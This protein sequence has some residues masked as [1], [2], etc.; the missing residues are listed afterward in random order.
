M[1]STS[2]DPKDIALNKN[3]ASS[4]QELKFILMGKR[5]KIFIL[6]GKRQKINTKYFSQVVFISAM[7]KKIK[8]R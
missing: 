8:A 4:F 2:L 6:M 7:K 3:N 1:P 5:Q